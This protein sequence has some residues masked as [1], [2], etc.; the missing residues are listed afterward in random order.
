MRFSMITVLFCIASAL[1]TPAFAQHTES[2]KQGK[3]VKKSGF[4]ASYKAVG[5]IT[6]KGKS[7]TYLA[8]SDT[9]AV[10][11][12]LGEKRTIADVRTKAGYTKAHTFSGAGEIYVHNKKVHYVPF[13]DL[14]TLA[15]Q[16]L[17]PMYK[18][19]QLPLWKRKTS[20]FGKPFNVRVNGVVVMNLALKV[21]PGSLDFKSKP[22]IE[23]YAKAQ[24]VNGKKGYGGSTGQLLL[25]RVSLTAH[26][27]GWNGCEGFFVDANVYRSVK[28]LA[29]KLVPWVKI[30]WVNGLQKFTKTLINYSGY[31]KKGTVLDVDGNI[32]TL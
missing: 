21:A 29:G 31:S 19:V 23:A 25:N 1:T 5:A 26:L 22:Y 6:V 28:L 16:S 24:M 30:N 3:S 2:F 8:Y 18:K 14:V 27:K 9:K 7:K 12:F 32:A 11:G 15:A 10:A 4:S 20:V 17:P 13:K